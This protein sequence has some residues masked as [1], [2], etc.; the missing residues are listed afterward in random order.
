MGSEGLFRRPG[1]PL[2]LASASP[3]RRE[4]LSEA[5]IQF[6]VFPADVDEIP[7]PGETPSQYASR[8]ARAKAMAV[9]RVYPR[10]WILGADTVV[11]LKDRIMGKPN[12]EEEACEMLRHLSGCQHEVLTA[13]TLMRFK[14]TTQIDIDEFNVVSQV[15]FRPLSEVEIDDYVKTREPMDKAGAYA[16]QGGAAGF[17]KTYTGSWSNIV[18]L[19]IEEVISHLKAIDFYPQSLR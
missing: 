2:I 14:S 5:G 10:H 18:G 15:S 4:L 9:S 16:I 8:V 3:R 12:T 19:P 7:H 17:V 13:V 1:I 6:E 11:F